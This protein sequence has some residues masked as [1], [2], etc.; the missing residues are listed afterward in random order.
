MG[1]KGDLKSISLA[2]VLQ[3]LAQ[4]EQNGT[5]SLTDEAKVWKTL[6]SAGQGVGAIADIPPAA[7][8]CERLIAEYRQAMADAAAD[9][10][11]RR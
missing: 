2:N 8:L 5:L 11:L 6:W 10:F 3:D 9:G 4:N 7:E 1:L